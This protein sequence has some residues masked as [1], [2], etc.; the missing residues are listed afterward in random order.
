MSQS[1]YQIVFTTCPDP[2]VAEQIAQTLVAE[3]LAACVNILPAMHSIYTWKG[4]M[5]STTEHL[6][7][8]KSQAHRYPAIQDR[9]RALHPYELP[10]IIAVPITHGLPDYLAWLNHP[11]KI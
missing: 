1:E 3:G 5:E 8:I 9:L 10:E 2:A 6:L 11:D 7:L 4:K